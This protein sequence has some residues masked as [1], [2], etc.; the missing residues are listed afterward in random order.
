MRQPRIIQ[1]AAKR[2]QPDASLP[3][4]LMPVELR[5]ARG[6]G[7]IAMPDVNI[8]QANGAIELIESLGKAFVADDVIASHVRVASIDASSRRHE[9][10]Q[11]VQQLGNL[12]EVAAERELGARRVLDQDTQVARRQVQT[13]D[14]LL[15]RQRNPLQTFFAAASAKR[16]GMQH[17]ELGAQSQRALH[18]AAKCHDRLGMK[19]RSCRPPG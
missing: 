4:V 7:I 5:S 8:L 16:A 2:L 12:F 6:L 19:F 3:D 14:R 13:L 18:L 17:Q 11:Q 10:A 9:V 15:D 1:Q